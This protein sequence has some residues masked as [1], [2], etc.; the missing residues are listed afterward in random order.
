MVLRRRVSQQQSYPTPD[1]ELALGSTVL[2]ACLMQ[3]PCTGGVAGDEG[4]LSGSGERQHR[5]GGQAGSYDV[6]TASSAGF[7]TGKGTEHL[8]T[9]VD[10]GYTNVVLVLCG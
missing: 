4:A 6:G 1:R 5:R 8:P 3:A 7:A 9:F 10:V 2:S